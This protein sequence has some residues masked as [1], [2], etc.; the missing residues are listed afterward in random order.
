MRDLDANCGRNFKFRQLIECGETWERSEGRIAN[1]PNQPETW[2]AM[3]MLSEKI[4]DRVFERY[5]NV[6]LTYGFSSSELSAAIKKHGGGISPDRDQHAG[7]ELNRRGKPICSRLGM[8]ADFRIAGIGSRLVA[9][10]ITENTEFDRLYFYG[11]EKPLHVSVG[12]QATGDI[13]EMRGLRG[14]RVPRRIR[15]IA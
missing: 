9:R 15:S 10:W 2:A 13:V 6:V 8:A 7:H 11:D 3:E 12:L 1:V 4:L 5:G 14:A